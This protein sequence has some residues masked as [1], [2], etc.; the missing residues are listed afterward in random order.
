M[1]FKSLMREREVVVEG[2]LAIIGG[3]ERHILTL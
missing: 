3:G 2:W 1:L